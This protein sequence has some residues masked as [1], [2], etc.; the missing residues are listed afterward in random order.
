LQFCLDEVRALTPE[1]LKLEDKATD[2]PKLDLSQRSQV[3]GT[4]SDPAAL[5]ESRLGDDRLSRSLSHSLSLGSDRV[6]GVGSC[7]SR[8]RSLDRWTLSRRRID[9]WTLSRRGIGRRGIGRR[10]SDLGLGRGR[11]GRLDRGQLE[12]MENRH[13]TSVGSVHRDAAI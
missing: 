6:V 3:P 4:P 1:A 5:A 10:R 9:R 12:G 13:R 2:V 7:L 11:V 8:R